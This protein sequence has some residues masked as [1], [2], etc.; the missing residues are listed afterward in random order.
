LFP[1]HTR[2]RQLHADIRAMNAWIETQVRRFLAR[3]KLRPAPR[4]VSLIGDSATAPACGFAEWIDELLQILA[5]EP[6]VKR[7]F[8][9][10]AALTMSIWMFPWQSD[11]L[12]AT[13]THAEFSHLLNTK[14]L[15]VISKVRRAEFS[16]W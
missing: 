1:A 12:V 2:D 9:L 11:S 14:L 10:S 8:S 15:G 6:G 5:W 13:C 3:I 7:A 16:R 4:T